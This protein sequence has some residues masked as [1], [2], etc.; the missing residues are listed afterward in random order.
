MSVE[1][2]ERL[3]PAHAQLRALYDPDGARVRT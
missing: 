2:E 1:I 3:V